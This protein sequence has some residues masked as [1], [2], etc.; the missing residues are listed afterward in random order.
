MIFIIFFF[1]SCKES[2]RKSSIAKIVSEWIGKEIMFPEWLECTS[3]GNKTNCIA[4]Y[5]ESFKILLYVDSLGC[6]SCRLNLSDWKKIMD[7]TNSEFITKPEFIFFFQPKKSDEKELQYILLSK[8]F[9]H[10]VFVDK[11]NLVNKINNFPSDPEYQCFLLDKNN[12]VVMVGNPS[13]NTGI[14]TLYKSIIN[15]EKETTTH[16]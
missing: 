16:L 4:L 9:R 6:T 1:T 3:M 14:W 2:K 8:G 13:Q 10:P 7:E 15:R 5:S 11:D 12:K